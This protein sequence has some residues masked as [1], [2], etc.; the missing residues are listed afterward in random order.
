MNITEMR[1]LFL[2]HCRLQGAMRENLNTWL[3]TGGALLRY[4]D[5]TPRPLNNEEKLL[6]IGCYQPSVG[7]Y[8]AL[9]WK[10][11]RGFFKED[12]EGTA[13]DH[14]EHAGSSVHLSKLDVE[15]EPIPVADGW[16]DAVIMMEVLEHF[17]VDP[18]HAL[19]EVNRVLKPGGR[20]IL[21]TPNGASWMS[22]HRAVRGNSAI[23]GLEFTGY[24]TNRHNR[25]YDC[26]ELPSI[27][28]SAGFTVHV[29]ESRD[30]EASPPPITMGERLFRLFFGALDALGYLVSGRRRERKHFITVLAEKSSPPKERWPV[31]LYFDENQWPGLQEQRARVLAN[32]KR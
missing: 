24:T 7:Y 1:N 22:L 18:M 4:R 9:G 20:L 6:E 3:G 26:V 2:D 12:G 25:I 19:W 23:N 31:S 28:A 8:I 27:L 14:Y 17:A 21:S 11:I 15:V 29:C 16:A 32:R 13:E 5:L 30:Y 10:H